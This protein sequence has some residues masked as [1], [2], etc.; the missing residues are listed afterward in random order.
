MVQSW[1]CLVSGKV[2]GVN[3]RTWVHDQATNLD[4]KG[5]V[6]NLYDGR[7]EILAQGEEQKIEEFKGRIAQGSPW[8]KI[9]HIESDW[10]DYEKEYQSFEL[11][12]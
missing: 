7:V 12:R 9:D 4:L 5:W 8:S 10:I 3:F 1:H 6:R 2:Q 11:R